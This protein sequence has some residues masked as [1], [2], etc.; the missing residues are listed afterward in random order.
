MPFWNFAPS[1]RRAFRKRVCIKSVLNDDLADDVARA[2][3]CN[4]CPGVVLMTE[5]RRVPVRLLVGRKEPGRSNFC[6]FR[7]SECILD[8]DAKI[9]HRVLDLGVAE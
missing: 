6:P 4:G 1:T 7:Q 3:V 9:A 8:V 5:I 2:V